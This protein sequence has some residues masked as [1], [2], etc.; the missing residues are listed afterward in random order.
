LKGKSYSQL[1]LSFSLI[2]L[3]PLVAD[4]THL[5]YAFI[6]EIQKID[7]L[8]QLNSGQEFMIIFVV[9]KQKCF[10]RFALYCLSWENNSFQ[11]DSERKA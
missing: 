8:L 9:T 5:H 10:P 1:H 4:D 3:H 6:M 11:E 2:Q 7:K